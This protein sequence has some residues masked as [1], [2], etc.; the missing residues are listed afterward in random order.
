MTESTLK[1]R[2]LTLACKNDPLFPIFSMRM[3]LCIIG[4]GLPPHTALMQWLVHDPD[5]RQPSIVHNTP[6]SNYGQCTILLHERRSFISGGCFAAP[7]E[8]RG[9]N[10]NTTSCT[11]NQHLPYGCAFA[12][13]SSY[14]V[15]VILCRFH[16]PSIIMSS[17]FLNFAHQFLDY[18]LSLALL[19]A[20][21]Y[22]DVWCGCGC[23]FCVS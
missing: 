12:W 8:R 14:F 6:N 1:G 10:D 3:L 2:E 13:L 19:T 16:H 7:V 22:D 4:V 20:M 11:M 5:L 23:W 17:N 21:T 18:I 9:S 15:P